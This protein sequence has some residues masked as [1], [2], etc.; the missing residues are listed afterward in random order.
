[1]LITGVARPY[2]IAT[3]PN[4]LNNKNLPTDSMRYH[5]VISPTP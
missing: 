3:A 4:I 1:M 2:D 5:M